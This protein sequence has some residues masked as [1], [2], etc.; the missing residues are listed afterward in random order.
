MT[1]K[2]QTFDP[3]LMLKTLMRHDVRFIVVGGVCCVLHGAPINTL[4][5][6][7]VH[8]RTFQNISRLLLALMQL[9]EVLKES[10]YHSP[11]DEE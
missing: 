7:I 11:G 10:Q 3:E 2:Y 6:D 1:N 8:D 5:L 9:R 4:D